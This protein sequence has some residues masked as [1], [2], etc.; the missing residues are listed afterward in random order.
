MKLKNKRIRKRSPN[1][2]I[3]NHR[4]E[5]TTR[6][7]RAALDQL[8]FRDP[9]NEKIIQLKLDQWVRGANLTTGR[10]GHGAVACQGSAFIIGGT[11]GSDDLD[12]LEKYDHFNN[13]WERI[14]QTPCSHSRPIKELLRRRKI[15]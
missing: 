13:I 6:I 8:K 11:N 4:T 15:T 14:R 12:S 5:V 2:E 10:Y 7:V 9:E 1:H 3:R